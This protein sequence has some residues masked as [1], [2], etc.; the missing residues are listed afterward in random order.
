MTLAIAAGDAC[1]KADLGNVPLLLHQLEPGIKGELRFKGGGCSLRAGQFIL[2]RR[3]WEV[4]GI[5]Q[6]AEREK[7]VGILQRVDGRC[8]EPWIGRK[9]GAQQSGAPQAKADDPGLERGRLIVPQLEFQRVG[10]ALLPGFKAG[11]ILRLFVRQ[12]RSFGQHR[13][14]LVLVAL[15]RGHARGARHRLRS[16]RGGGRLDDMIGNPIR[17]L[18]K[19]ISGCVDQGPGLQRPRVLA[20]RRV[21]A[22]GGRRDRGC[23]ALACCI[24]CAGSR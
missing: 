14:R 13:A 1:A 12:R 20:P 9:D 23:G 8:A 6:Q 17:L 3:D 5:G 24:R 15:D 7:Q 19:A 18:L 4:L 10:L 11:L 21:L 2:E 22:R 16:R